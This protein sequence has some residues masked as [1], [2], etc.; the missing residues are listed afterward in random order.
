MAMVI[1]HNVTNEVKDLTTLLSVNKVSAR[2]DR[3]IP[4]A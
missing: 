3:L 2:W 1:S 4:L